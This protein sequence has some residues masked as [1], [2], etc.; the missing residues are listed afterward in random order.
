MH[1]GGEPCG[2]FFTRYK[3]RG[4]S[5]SVSRLSIA[6]YSPE[7]KIIIPEGL[8]TIFINGRIAGFFIDIAQNF[9]HFCGKQ[10]RISEEALVY[11]V[12]VRFAVNRQPVA[13]V[14]GYF[15]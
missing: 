9:A 3:A 7:G 15:R 8:L 6:F 12:G 5:K 14:V 10:S 13:E 2:G 11:N 1:G 4:I